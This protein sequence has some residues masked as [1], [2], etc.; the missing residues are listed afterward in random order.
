MRT[1]NQRTLVLTLIIILLGF[2][3]NAKII[4]PRIFSNNMVL[5]RDIPV[6]IWGWA[7]AGEKITVAFKGNTYINQAD[8]SGNWQITLP[9]TSAGG[10]YHITISGE[11]SMELSNVLF[12]DVWVCSGQS[13][14]Y[15][16]TAAAKNAYIDIQAANYDKIRLFQIDKD[17]KHVPQKDLVSGE[18]QECTPRTVYGFSAV[19]YFFG[20]EIHREL[21]V[22]IGLIHASWG[23][24]KIQ[25]WMDEASIKE[26]SDYQEQVEEIEQTPDY[27]ATLEKEYEKKG[28]N[29]LVKA[30]Y[31][32]DPGFKADGTLSTND[33][34]SANGWQEIGVPGYW[35]D[36]R[37][38]SYDGTLWYRKQFELPESFQHR[39]LLLD[40]G[41]IDDYDFTFFNGELV[42]KTFY[43]GSERRYEIPSALIKPRENE[44]IVCVY[45]YSGYGG[46]WGPSK[47][48]IRKLNDRADLQID[49]QGLWK[50]KP[51]ISQLELRISETNKQPRKRDIP[52]F[53]FNSMIAPLTKYSIKGVIW[54]QGE[55]NADNGAEYAKL[56]PAMISG[57]RRSW[58]Q[59]DFPFLFVQL[60]NYGFPTDKPT[61][62]NWAEL[63][64]AQLTTLSLPGTAMVVT[65]DLGDKMNIHPTNKQEVGRRLAISAQKVA[66]H[67]N[68]VNSGPVFRSMEIRE[69]K[70]YINFNHMGTGLVAKDKFGY[71]KE[72][73]IAGADMEFVWAK[74]LVMGHQVVVYNEKIKNPKAVRY[75]WSD[76]PSQANLYNQQGLPATPFRTDN[77]EN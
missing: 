28:G 30:I 46:F 23:G 35:E 68:I 54:Y 20:R 44:I 3:L 36:S 38:P 7:D 73:A 17:A 56:F 70:A 2:G 48:Q 53:L 19:A 29:F 59:G 39:D 43:K 63:R 42:G 61:Q 58:K 57:W 12:G 49:L 71:L 18:W 47:S 77:W 4:L 24:S 32:K 25:A 5:Q 52:T 41:W 6:T 16:R 1:F 69:G 8:S 22:P 40:L 10:P 67:K 75:A 37:L 64:E 21:D 14:M 34:F 72:F 62:S 66:Y 31:E 9:E 45:D 76:N 65:I 13:N 74:A 60:A 26:F 33:F 15:F 11:N 27:F 51:G 55:G 50:F